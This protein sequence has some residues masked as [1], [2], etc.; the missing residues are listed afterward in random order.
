MDILFV[1][2]EVFPFARAGGLGDVS[3]YLPRALADR[4]HRLWV[5]T[6]K[7]RNSEKAG[8]ELVR[9]DLSVPVPLSWREK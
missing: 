3:H 1:S 4:G 9:R 6:P 5:I 7:Y 8:H 2:P